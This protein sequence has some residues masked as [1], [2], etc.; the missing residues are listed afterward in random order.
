M[1]LTHKEFSLNLR[2]TSRLAY[3]FYFFKLIAKTQSAFKRQ[4]FLR[5][6]I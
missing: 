1:R 2:K 5:L 4:P 6:P 3:R